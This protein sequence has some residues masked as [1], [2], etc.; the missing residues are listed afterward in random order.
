MDYVEDVI[1]SNSINNEGSNLNEEF[2]IF[3]EKYKEID[4]SETNV[5][6]AKSKI[7]GMS[8]GN[9][10]NIFKKVEFEKDIPYE[11]ETDEVQLFDELEKVQKNNGIK[12]F[13]LT[14]ETAKKSNGVFSKFRKITNTKNN[15]FTDDIW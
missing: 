5:I 9:E 4:F 12:N 8:I 14:K 15:K 7:E 6:S 10:K 11:I 2:D 3:G 13:N 1:L